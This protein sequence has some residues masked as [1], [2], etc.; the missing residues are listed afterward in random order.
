MKLPTEKTH[1]HLKLYYLLA[2][3]FLGLFNGVLI[4]LY[5]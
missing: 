4:G 1:P 2:L 5:L 3:Y